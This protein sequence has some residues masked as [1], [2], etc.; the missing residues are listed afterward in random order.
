MFSDASYV[1]SGFNTPNFMNINNL[2]L[3]FIFVHSCDIV[4]VWL[5]YDKLTHSSQIAWMPNAITCVDDIVLGC[6]FTYATIPKT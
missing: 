5:L 3:W 1:V 2:Q 6:R 4:S